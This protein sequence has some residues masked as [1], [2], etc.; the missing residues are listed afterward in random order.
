MIFK[1]I[2]SKAS[3]SDKL[4]R[5]FPSHDCYIELFAGS[6]SLFF[7]KPLAKY[8]ILNDIDED[9][10]N[11]WEVLK[12][13]KEALY[14]EIKNLIIHEKIWQKYKKEVVTD[15]VFR[16]ALFV[17][18]SNFGYMCKDSTL[19]VECNNTKELVLS[20]IKNVSKKIESV[21]FTCGDFRECIR[22]LSTSIKKEYTSFVYADP[23]YVSCKKQ[24]YKAKF[25]EN[26][27]SDLLD[28]LTSSGIN[29]G[30]SEY[31]HPM[32][33]D[34]AQQYNL[35]INTVCNKR[36]LKNRNT[37]V[38]LTNYDVQNLFS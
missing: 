32:I 36:T 15:P 4:I 14:E 22:S 27:L 26:D 20:R 1:R 18:Y 34:F 5:L 35:N 17:M 9:I 19:Q 13:Q 31:N 25:Y 7:A 12:F 38:L 33:I 37:E 3:F 8:N 30:I 28:S 16:A 11:F 6:G 10:Y 2:G 24:H 23:P 21:I 29:F